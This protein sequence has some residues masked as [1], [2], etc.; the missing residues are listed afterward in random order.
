VHLV[1]AGIDKMRRRRLQVLDKKFVG[2]EGTSASE[3]NRVGGGDR[4]LFI[5]ALGVEEGLGLRPGGGDR[6]DGEDAVQEKERLA[7]GRD[8]MR[9]PRV[10]E[11][12]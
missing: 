11:G 8:D 3:K 10:S 2:L 5:A 7:G 4:G 12:R 1:C 6:T 9:A